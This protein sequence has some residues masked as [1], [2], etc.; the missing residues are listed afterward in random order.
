MVW[1]F[2]KCI[3]LKQFFLP[4][5]MQYFEQARIKKNR[6]KK[7]IGEQAVEPFF[8]AWSNARSLADATFS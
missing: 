5:H 8:I 7:N 1:F 3:P 6:A 4:D 2:E